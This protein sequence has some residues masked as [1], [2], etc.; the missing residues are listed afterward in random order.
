AKPHQDKSKWCRYHK[1]H[2]HV[3]EECIHLKDAIEVLIRDGHLKR[4][5]QNKENPRPEPLQASNVKEEKPASGG[6]DLK[7]VAMCISR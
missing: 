7:Q 1:A 3:T 2:G 5:V 4:F 6:Q